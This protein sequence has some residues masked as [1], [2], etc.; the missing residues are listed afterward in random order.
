[1]TKHWILAV[2]VFWTNPAR[3]YFGLPSGRCHSACIPH[4]TSRGLSVCPFGHT[5]SPGPAA[6]RSSHSAVISIVHGI[7][8]NS[9]HVPDRDHEITPS[10]HQMNQIRWL[11]N[12]GTWSSSCDTG[13]VGFITF[14]CCNTT[15]RRN[16]FAAISE[17]P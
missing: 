7:A 17:S 3:L 8:D 15:P 5:E 10:G 2:P 1:M 4:T 14:L 6:Q 9:C 13:P 16:W 12:F 11:R